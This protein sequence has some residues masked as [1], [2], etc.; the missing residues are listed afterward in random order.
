MESTL[1]EMNLHRNDEKLNFL[2][3]GKLRVSEALEIS[4]DLKRKLRTCPVMVN[5]NINSN[6]RGHFALYALWDHSLCAPAVIPNPEVYVITNAAT[7]RFQILKTD[8]LQLEFLLYANELSID[9]R[10]WIIFTLYCFFHRRCFNHET[11]D[12]A[13]PH[14]LH[15]RSLYRVFHCLDYT[16]SDQRLISRVSITVYEIYAIRNSV[17][18]Q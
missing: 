3:G 5:R 2:S 7:R 9:T 13:V 10:R 14:V 1:L 4:K 6:R 12:E 17:A 16:S 8:I 15:V 18:N 11:H